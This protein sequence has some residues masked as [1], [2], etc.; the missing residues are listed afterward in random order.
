MS[1]I[2]LSL[3]SSYNQQEAM[4]E[5]EITF[6]FHFRLDLLIKYNILFTF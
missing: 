5:V 6:S 4:T 3:S 2:I 1:K